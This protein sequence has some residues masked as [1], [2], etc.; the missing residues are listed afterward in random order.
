M[1]AVDRLR[2]TRAQHYTRVFRSYS[3]FATHPNMGW[4]FFPLHLCS[5]VPL[6]INNEAGATQPLKRKQWKKN[7]IWIEKFDL[8][9]W[10]FVRRM[11]PIYSSLRPSLESTDGFGR[12]KEVESRRKIRE[13]CSNCVYVIW[14][15]SKAHNNQTNKNE[16][17]KRIFA[18]KHRRTHT[19][20]RF[21]SSVGWLSASRLLG[22]RMY[23]LWSPYLH[24]QRYF[25]SCVAS[26]WLQ[27]PCYSCRHV[28]YA[29]ARTSSAQTV[30]GGCFWWRM[31]ARECSSRNH[32][33]SIQ[34]PH[35]IKV[36]SNH[37]TPN[38]TSAVYVIQ[39]KQKL[40]S[41][42]I[43]QFGAISLFTWTTFV[44]FSKFV[45]NGTSKST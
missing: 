28:L 24:L 34:A 45:S 35:N 23:L 19:S 2:S 44:S 16:K 4:F 43:F 5:G 17:W 27:P 31:R 20:L 1:L 37:W 26:S 7:S 32:S 36:N 25:S 18:E 15:F 30:F 11:H 41:I 33:F 29:V 10:D 9:F 38:K 14:I 3:K 39:N 6:L 13:F 8:H 12:E 21:R 42:C 22:V 40:I